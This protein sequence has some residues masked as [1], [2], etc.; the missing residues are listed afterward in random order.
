MDL[1]KKYGPLAVVAAVVLWFL[2]RRTGE[3]AKEVANAITP[4]NPNNVFYRG[5]NAVGD[6][7]DDAADNDSF[8][9]GSYI[10]DLLHGR[11]EAEKLRE[12]YLTPQITPYIYGDIGFD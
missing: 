11:Q 12:S 5:V 4:T 8:S 2:G 10:Y 6:V 7:L 1:L 3:A 9:L